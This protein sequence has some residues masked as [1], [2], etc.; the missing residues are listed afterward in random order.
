MI[1]LYRIKIGLYKHFTNKLRLDY[2]HFSLTSRM[3][4]LELSSCR[5]L[6]KGYTITQ[7]RFIHLRTVSEP[8]STAPRVWEQTCEAAVGKR[9]LQLVPVHDRKTVAYW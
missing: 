4:Q 3:R 2:Q 7:V 9:S 5:N 6:I 8:T 1:Y